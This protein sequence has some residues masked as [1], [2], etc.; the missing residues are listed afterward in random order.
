[1]R[2]PTQQELE[3][4]SLTERV[5]FEIADTVNRRPAL[6]R[7][8]HAFHNSVGQTWVHYSTRHLVHS[9][10]LD[11]LKSLRPDRGVFLVSN[12]R[13]FFDFYCISSVLLRAC[14]W[15]RGIYFPVRSNFFYEGVAGN[16]VNMVMSAWAMYPPVM[17]APSKRGFNAYT[18]DAIDALLRGPGNLI[19]YHPE[20]RRGTGPDPYEMLPASI[21]TG[22]IVYRARPVVIPVF[23]LGLINN[24]PQQ[25]L[26]NFNGRGEPVTMVFGEP[27]DLERFYAMPADNETYKAIAE[28][29]RDAIIALSVDE[30]A[31]RRAKGLRTLD[32]NASTPD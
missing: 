32:P 1:M 23:T 10:G 8:A 24:F 12:H 27:L 5:C 6:K 15:V 7:A 9:Q 28:H 13:S 22:S 3:L 17:R 19:G 18:L 21:G 14:S 30:R 16:F 25:V 20:G 4:L 2:R 11:R 31:L 29:I 26:G